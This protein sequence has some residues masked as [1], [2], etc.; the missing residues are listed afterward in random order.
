MGRSPPGRPAACRKDRERLRAGPGVRL[1]E[2]STQVAVSH[3][4]DG[5]ARHVWEG[6]PGP[7]RQPDAGAG[8]WNDGT[9]PLRGP[10]LRLLR[11]PDRLGDGPDG[12]ARPVGA[13]ARA[14]PGR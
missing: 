13:P 2:I 6:P 9:H 5:R 14:G 11:H 7:A 10:E 12:R 3:V 4:T 1:A 8:P